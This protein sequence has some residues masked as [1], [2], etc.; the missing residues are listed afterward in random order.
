MSEILLHKLNKYKNKL[1]N[2]PE[3]EIYQRKI[4][5]YSGLIWGGK[6]E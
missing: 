4:E 5:Y 3:N 2:N 6:I 1:K